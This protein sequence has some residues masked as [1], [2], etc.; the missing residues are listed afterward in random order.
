MTTK[1]VDTI[2]TNI[3]CP[4]IAVMTR[5][6]AEVACES[7]VEGTTGEFDSGGVPPD[8]TGALALFGQADDDGI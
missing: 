2:K 1:I 8:V 4:I 5:A 7:T 6:S 3:C